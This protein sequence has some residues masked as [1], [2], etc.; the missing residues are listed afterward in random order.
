MDLERFMATYK[1]AWE[2]SDADLLASLFAADGVYHNT[3]F[4]E[5]EG[6]DSIRA[7][8]QRTKL[9][10]DILVRYQLVQ[11]HARGGVARWH[12]TYQVTSEELFKTWAASAGTGMLP[13]QP[14]DPLPRLALDGV[15]LVELDASGLCRHFRIWWHSAV[16]G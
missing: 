4:A 14:G 1:Q 7:Y 9:Q 13:R 16:A 8:W 2:T 15:A 3:P 10:K 12:T 6:H 11:A 5:Q